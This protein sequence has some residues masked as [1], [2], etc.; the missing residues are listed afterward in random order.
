M[1]ALRVSA[2]WQPIEALAAT[3][4][5]LVPELVRGRRG[6]GN[7]AA[8]CDLTARSSVDRALVQ[9]SDLRLSFVRDTIGKRPQ[10]KLTTIE[11]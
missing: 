7:A 11:A 5:T 3:K 4:R 8:Q 1:T 6:L 2:Y 9:N 10:A